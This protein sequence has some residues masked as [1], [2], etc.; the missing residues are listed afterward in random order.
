M[1]GQLVDKL[2][3]WMLGW[4]SD[5]AASMLRKAAAAGQQ[6]TLQSQPAARHLLLALCDH[7]EPLWSGD[8]KAPGSAPHD[9]AVARVAAWRQG[10][11][12]LA[13]RVRD[14]DGHPPRHTFFF[15]GDQY[16][17]D[18][19]E[20][21]AELCGLGLGEVELHLHHG[22]D[23]RSSLARKIQLSLDQFCT[24]GVLSRTRQGPRWAFIHGDWALANARAD[25]AHCGVDD[26]LDLLYELGC[27]ADFTFPS[28]Q[29]ETQP[30]KVNAIYYPSG[31]VRRRRSFVRGLPAKVG[32]PAEPRVLMIQ[33]PLA[34]AGGTRPGRPIRIDSGALT[35]QDPA[36]RERLSTWVA[37]GVHVR[38]RPEWTFVKLHTHG[39]PELHAESLLGP[40]QQRFH[41]ALAELARERGMS[42]HFVTAREMFNIA[43][44]AMDGKTGNP[45]AFRDYEIPPPERALVRKAA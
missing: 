43:R 14:A 35:A 19:L 17:P 20:P 45:S 44:A 11:P 3:P 26:E 12:K 16:H 28:V 41:D 10:Y 25:G 15:A 18:L 24:H 22:G 27:Y 23:T 5:R 32:T 31:D 39:A 29:K 13:A 40:P 30:M 9:R 37:Q 33:G 1:I 36:T 4:A 7:Y 42:V 38:G 2:S 6:V 21:I 34:L 8:P